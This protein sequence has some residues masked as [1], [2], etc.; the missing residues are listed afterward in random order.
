MRPVRKSIYSPCQAIFF[1]RWLL[2]ACVVPMSRLQPTEPRPVWNVFVFTFI[3]VWIHASLKSV[4]S[5]QQAEWLETGLSYLKK[6]CP[7]RNLPD[8]SDCARPVPK[9]FFPKQINFGDPPP[10]SPKKFRSV[11]HCRG[12]IFGTSNKF[13]NIT[14]LTTKLTEFPTKLTEF[15]PFIFI[16]SQYCPTVKRIL[17]DC[18]LPNKLGGPARYAHE[19]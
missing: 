9:I 13:P 15:V 16:I 2:L 6:I 10:P 1:F 19:F 5:V 11:Y 8:F 17:P 7:E 12:T 3:P 18:F 4:G 14:K